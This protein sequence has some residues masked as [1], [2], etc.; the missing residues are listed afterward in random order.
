MSMIIHLFQISY[1]QIKT[2]KQFL[3][4]MLITWLMR[5]IALVAISVM[6]MSLITT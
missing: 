6:Q 4:G 3:Y 1:F 2:S 5:E